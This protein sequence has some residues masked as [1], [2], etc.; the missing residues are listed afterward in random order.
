MWRPELTAKASPGKLNR[1][2]RKQQNKHFTSAGLGVGIHCK[3]K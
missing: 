3:S 2:F 1:L